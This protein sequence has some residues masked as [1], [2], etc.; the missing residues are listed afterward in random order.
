[1]PYTQSQL[2]CLHG[3]GIVPWV[4][5]SACHPTAAMGNSEVT[6]E[7]EPDAAITLRDSIVANELHQKN[8][9]DQK[10]ELHQHNGLDP[11]VALDPNNETLSSGAASIAEPTDFMQTPLVEIPFRGKL[12]M[13]LGKSDALLLILVEAVSTQQNQYPFE[14]ADAKVFDDML[15]AIAWRRQD[16][17]LGVLPPSSAP[18]LIVD[19]NALTV[20]DLCKPHRD[21]VLL[22]RQSVPDT[23]NVDELIL[24]LE[25]AGMLAWQLPHPALLR[26]YP[27]R[28]RQAWN[29]LKA[30]RARL[31]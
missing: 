14:P 16:V 10:N 3:M 5:R 6:P 31:S 17:C 8:K 26:E 25:R 23:R 21:A 7:V 12:C 15:R 29:V 19:N 30:A 28:K 24:P 13:Q 9:L 20:S 22:F 27:E 1:M 18:S 2:R 4:E 11:N